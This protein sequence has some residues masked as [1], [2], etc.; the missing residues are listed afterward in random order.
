M[1]VPLQSF[2][3]DVDCTARD[4][5]FVTSVA[6][7]LGGH[8]TTAAQ[9]LARLD[10]GDLLSRDLENPR[11]KRGFVRRAVAEAARA[12][13]ERENTARASGS[14]TTRVSISDKFPD[15]GLRGQ[16]AQS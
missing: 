16:D 14:A 2:L 10:V 1:T 12:A 7:W 8:G 15:M 3:G 13:T 9:D 4:A 11:L 6:D 5:T